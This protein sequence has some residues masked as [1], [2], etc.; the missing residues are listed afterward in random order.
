M[1]LVLKSKRLVL[2]IPKLSDAPI[3]EKYINDFLVSCYLT[4]VPFPYPRG[5]MKEWIKK[6]IQQQKIKNI[7]IL[8]IGQF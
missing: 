4:N 6:A 2:R 8:F 1:N 5:G 7:T 3:L